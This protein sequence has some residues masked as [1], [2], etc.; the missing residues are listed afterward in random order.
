MLQRIWDRMYLGFQR[1]Y[2]NVWWR[3]VRKNYTV[4]RPK[5]SKYTVLIESRDLIFPTIEKKVLLVEYSFFLIN[6]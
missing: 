5:N 6:E 3:R 4:V 2:F 1:V